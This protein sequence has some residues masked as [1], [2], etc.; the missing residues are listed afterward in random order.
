M[1]EGSGRGTG[2]S[3]SERLQ[4]SLRK[5]LNSRGAD[6][7]AV[8]KYVWPDEPSQANAIGEAKTQAL[9]EKRF[10][11]AQ[12]GALLHYAIGTRSLE[13]EYCGHANAIVSSQVRLEELDLHDALRELQTSA[14]ID[15]TSHVISCPNCAA[16]FALDGHVH[17]GECP[18]CGTSVV[19]E[20]S[21]SKPI[22]PRGLLPFAVTDEDA[23]EA[24]KTWLKRRWFAPNELKKYARSDAS[25]NGVYIPYWTYDSD[26]VTAYRG[27]RGEVY[28]VRQRY[29]TTVNGRRVTRVRQVPKI[30]WY[31]TSGKTSRHFD[32]VLV[33]ATRTLPRKITDWLAPWDLENLEP[34]TEDYLAGFS[35]EVYQVDLDEGF[36]IAQST[37]D[38]VIRGDVKRSIGGD[39][40]RIT[41]LSTRH[42]DTTFKHVLLPLWTAGF[43]F[44][45]KTYRFVV[46][47][48]TG[49]VQGERP[50]SIVKIALAGMAG[51]ALAAVFLLLASQSQG[52]ASLN[53]RF[54]S[55]IG[56]S[57]S[58]DWSSN[59]IPSRW[60]DSPLRDRFRA[61]DDLLPKV[62]F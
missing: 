29:T 48:R 32:D 57:I 47:G 39:Q 5:R 3:L 61:F 46:N 54:S 11:C 10:P 36:N 17:A 27:Q 26:T 25:L 44:R 18:F 45:G 59:P 37:M 38:Q 2:S 40:Q 19:T 30:R 6:A 14:N 43:Q 52:L 35:S 50:Y 56:E 4:A 21:R 9:T 58:F 8:G 28:Y 41:K 13:C 60:P 16:Q 51:V 1:E 23:R 7:P 15:P 20:T 55:G 42:S 12:C 34:Y 33:G 49:K 62:D 22:K 31:P 24:Y 53:G